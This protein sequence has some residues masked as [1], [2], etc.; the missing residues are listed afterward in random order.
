MSDHLR[1][2]TSNPIN[3]A[4]TE[5]VLWHTPNAEETVAE[6]SGRGSLVIDTGNATIHTA[7]TAGECREL[8][9]HLLAMA[10]AIEA[11]ATVFQPKGE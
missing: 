2:Y 1:M 8:A 4:K 10:D 3:G 7:P 6:F 9:S 11:D 5:F